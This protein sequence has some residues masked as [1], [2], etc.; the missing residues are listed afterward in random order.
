MINTD[1]SIVAVNVKRIC[2]ERGLKHKAVAERTGH[3]EKEFSNMLCGRKRIVADDIPVIA[4]AL[5]VMPNE[6]FRN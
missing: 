4:T 6:L 5:G 3:S 1:M 2:S